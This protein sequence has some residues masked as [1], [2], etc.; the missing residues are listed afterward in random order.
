MDGRYIDNAP[1]SADLLAQRWSL[2]RDWA[3]AWLNQN[4]S[5]GPQEIAAALGSLAEDAYPECLRLNDRAFLVSVASPLG[6]VFILAQ[7]NG[8]YRVAWSTDQEQR[9]AGKQRKALTAWRARNS[10]GQ[11]AVNRPGPLTP[12]LGRLSADANGNSRFYIDA[13]YSADEG[14]TVDAQFS[15]WLWNGSTAVP[16]LVHEYAKFIDQK[17]GIR[18]EGG[19][20]KVQEKKFFRAFFSCGMCEERQVDWIVRVTP[21][22]FQYLGEKSLVPELDVIDELLYRVIHHRSSASLASASAAS[23]ARRMVREQQEQ[24][25]PK[26][27]KAFPSIGMMGEWAIR[28]S[29]G[30]T[31]LCLTLDPGGSNNLFTMKST[32]G[33]FFIT[34]IQPIS[35]EC[36]SVEH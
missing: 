3:A 16:Q 22:N 24:N 13:T 21:K 30:R 18:L 11:P 33:R 6:N 26:D 1:E 19:L 5:A 36:R 32:G 29:R 17:A 4:P 9:N 23:Y 15:L 10:Q 7:S 12:M 2:L 25:T 31:V 8:Q 28:Q 35:Q 34:R 27:W 14:G 20:L